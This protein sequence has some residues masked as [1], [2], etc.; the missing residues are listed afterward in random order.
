MS[1]TP[2]RRATCRS[3]DA[4]ILWALTAAGN[5]IPIDYHPNPAGN[6]RLEL[7]RSAHTSHTEA[8]VLGPLEQAI[9][10][11]DGTEL[12]MPHHATCPHGDT[13]RK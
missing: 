6:V 3:C 10:T 5:R 13:W 12:Y 9:A 8:T 7:V 11:N 1:D 2:R 4:P